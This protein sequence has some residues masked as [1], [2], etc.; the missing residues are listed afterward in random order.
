MTLRS[1]WPDYYADF[2]RGRPK[3]VS[4]ALW[5]QAFK[6]NFSSRYTGM[7]FEDCGEDG[8]WKS[9]AGT[10]D[11]DCKEYQEHHK[12]AHPWCKRVDD[13]SPSIQGDG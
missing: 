12:L 5:C 2:L 8:C 3:E 10:G 11:P 6:V 7:Y 13:S 4:I 9:N 1:I